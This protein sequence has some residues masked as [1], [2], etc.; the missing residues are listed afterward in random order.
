MQ[1]PVRIILRGRIHAAGSFE[2][3]G[4]RIGF[5]QRSKALFLGFLVGRSTTAKEAGRTKRHKRKEQEATLG[6]T[7]AAIFRISQEQAGMVRGAFHKQNRI[8]LV[9]RAVAEVGY[10]EPVGDSVVPDIT[11]YVSHFHHD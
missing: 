1:R 10:Q 9:C 7:A 4:R 3:V 6:C 11:G 5:P 8:S 2:F